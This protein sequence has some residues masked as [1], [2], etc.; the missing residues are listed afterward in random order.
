[1]RRGGAGKSGYTS[2]DLRR[3]EPANATLGVSHDF[4]LLVGRDPRNRQD[5]DEED[6][7]VPFLPFRAKARLDERVYYLL[8]TSPR[9]L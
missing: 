7:L 5:A 8:P 9:S 1:M 4:A 3:L 6:S 2:F